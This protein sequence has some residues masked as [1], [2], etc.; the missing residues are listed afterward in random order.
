MSDVIR[1][2]GN[3]MS[4]GSIKVKIGNEL[5]TGFTEITFGDKRERVKGYGMGRHHA[6]RSR[7]RGKYVVDPVKL[8][9]YKPSVQALRDALAAQSA[10]GTSYGNT[11]AQIIVQAIEPDETPLHIEINRCVV[12][13]DSSSHTESSDPLMDD[14]EMD[15]M[16]IRRNGKSLFD[17]T[18]GAP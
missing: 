5:Y 15:A 7:T 6:P 9:G 8:K 13:S 1:V 17:G 16:S 14:L 4:W 2:N 11:E 12:V 18:E 10:D 3:E